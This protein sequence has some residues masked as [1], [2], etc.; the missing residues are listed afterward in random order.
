MGFDAVTALGVDLVRGFPGWT[1]PVP[2]KS[3]GRTRCG[4]AIDGSQDRCRCRCLSNPPNR[5]LTTPSQ[6]SRGPSPRSAKSP[7]RHSLDPI[8]AAT[9]IS[10]SH[11]YN[12]SR[13][14]TGTERPVV[15][16]TNP[17][18]PTRASFALVHEQERRPIQISDLPPK[19]TTT[20]PEPTSLLAVRF[21]TAPAGRVPVGDNLE[22]RAK[23]PLRPAAS[24][25][26]IVEVW[27]GGSSETRY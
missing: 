4:P 9:R 5:D 26:R 8:A 6:S 11:G 2:R 22:Q 24:P 27:R 21:H 19:T 13:L 3:A 17:L 1:V 18:T 20:Y 25:A 23:H 15:L 14:R 7:C 16:D 10:A 12:E